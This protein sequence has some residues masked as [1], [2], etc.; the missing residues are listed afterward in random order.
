M[1]IY[2]NLIVNT[3][4]NYPPFLLNLS[5]FR[6]RILK[7]TELRILLGMIEKKQN[8][9]NFTEEEKELHAKLINER[10]F[11]E[12]EELRKIEKLLYERYK[13]ELSIT[14]EDFRF[15]IQ[16]THACN[17]NCYYCFE[18]DYRSH[19]FM[20]E[21]Q[22]DAIQE[23]Y[24]IASYESGVV[25]RTPYI[26]IT[27]GEPLLNKKTVRIINYIASKWPLSKLI[28]YTNGV[29]VLKYYDLLPFS[30]IK[31]F[32]I[33][34]DGIKDVH[35]ERRYSNKKVKDSIY[36]DIINGI[37]KLLTNGQNIQIKVT[38]DKTNYIFVSDLLNYLQIQQILNSPNCTY[39]INVVNDFQN[40][41]D[42][43][44]QYNSSDDIAKIKSYFAD[45]LGMHNMNFYHC[46]SC[47]SRILERDHNSRML[48]N[49]NRCD[50]RFLSN[51]FFS[52]NG[53]V[54]LCDCLD[55]Q[56]GIV[57]TYY[58]E[59]SFNGEKVLALAN[60]NVFE[61]EECKECI[62]KF[63]CLGGCPMIAEMKG[64]KKYCGG[65]KDSGLI[66]Q[67]SFLYLGDKKSNA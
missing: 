37:K 63:V 65:F 7:K 34:L 8:Y 67:F 43:N 64:V 9:A 54:Y 61:D 16:L 42:I 46:F 11:L 53:S 58:P 29:N 62:Y 15:S 12:N 30:Q 60:R 50:T 45:D 3:S 24:Y 44:E 38:I 1:N 59:V 32:C 10:Q 5:S 52:P 40:P 26:R 48:P 17:M 57:G 27:G 66:D 22:V 13:E 51:Y 41:L 2:G 35:L 25:A 33:S 4:S 14:R 55:V 49:F 18:E 47:L 31:E 28:L 20:N 19:T 6:R 56:K 36:D 39:N 21:D 23:F